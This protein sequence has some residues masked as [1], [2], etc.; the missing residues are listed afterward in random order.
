MSN[1]SYSTTHAHHGKDRKY[2]ALTPTSKRRKKYFL[3][4]S[5]KINIW[6]KLL[7]SVTKFSNQ[8]CS[9]LT[10]G[11]GLKLFD[12]ISC[13]IY[14]KLRLWDR[15]HVWIFPP[16]FLPILQPDQVVDL[17]FSCSFTVLKSAEKKINYL[18]WL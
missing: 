6:L 15:E 12:E 1:S 2:S 9:S 11:I 16:L 18:I 14:R 3:F 5:N 13:P 10:S 8:S 17:S 7:I 4:L